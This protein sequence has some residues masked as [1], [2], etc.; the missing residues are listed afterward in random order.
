MSESAVLALIKEQ[1]TSRDDSENSSSQRGGVQRKYTSFS[2]LLELC[3]FAIDDANN[4]L[5]IL[6]LN[7]KLIKIR[8]IKIT[9]TV[10]KRYNEKSSLIKKLRSVKLCLHLQRLD[11]YKTF[12]L[13]KSLR[14]KE[15]VIEIFI[16]RNLF[17]FS[18]KVQVKL[19]LENV[20]QF[21]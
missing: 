18:D 15:I 3:K 4:F 10:L 8:L 6:Q 13:Y 14:D 7:A 17:V 12:V 19:T 2:R 21:N 5:N 16:Q 11:L 20:K 1:S 9:D